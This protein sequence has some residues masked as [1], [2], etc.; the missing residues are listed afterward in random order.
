MRLLNKV[1]IVTGA[2]G[3]IGAAQCRLFARERAKVVVADIDEEK[4]FELTNKISTE[5]G[6]ALFVNLDVTSES[7]WSS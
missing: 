6:S 3:G 1:V 2:T 7:N 4:G 5:G